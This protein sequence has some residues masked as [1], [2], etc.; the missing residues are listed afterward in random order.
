MRLVAAIVD[1]ASVQRKNSHHRARN[2]S[3]ARLRAWRQLWIA[4]A[5]GESRLK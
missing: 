2:A 1:H 4:G 3:A 5:T